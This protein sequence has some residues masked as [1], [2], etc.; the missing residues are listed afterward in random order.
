M[1]LKKLIIYMMCVL[2]LVGC[3][4]VET[5]QEVEDN[6]TYT[7]QEEVKESDTGSSQEAPSI[8]I[9]EVSDE[10]FTVINDNI[11][12]FE[13]ADFTTSSFEQYS[14]LDALGRCGIA[15]ANIGLDLMP[16]EERESISQVKPTGWQSVKY[17]IVD[18]K[19]LYNRCH[20]I[21]HQL[22]GENANENNLITGTRYFNVDGM[23]PF[24]NMVAD[25]IKET[26][27]HVL[28]RVTPVYEGND[29]VA[30]GVQI[31]AMS[32]EDMG[33]GIS[34]NVFVYN[35]QPG[36]VIDY[37]TGESYLDDQPF[38]YEEN[39]MSYD[40]EGADEKT[41]SYV[42]N[43]NSKKFHDVSCV[44]VKRISEVNK[45]TYTGTYEE[46][47]NM[48]YEPCKNCNPQ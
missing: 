25:Y 14:E 35:Q 2:M 38:T 31:E 15:Y 42:L 1:R 11:P 9:Q 16:T 46:I 41:V 28:Y 29:L 39:E 3:G 23:L 36:I 44:S 5:L 45:D 20:L 37:A 12:N 13:A 21:G 10:P 33:E 19:Y 43:T 40:N 34:F 4:T 18:G 24:E 8:D 17:D 48:G 47:I 22:T 27:N 32:V 6:V 26:G 7:V 30:K